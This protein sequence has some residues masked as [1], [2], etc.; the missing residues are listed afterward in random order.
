MKKLFVLICLLALI[1]FTG[2]AL[3]ASGGHVTSDDTSGGGGGGCNAGYAGIILF[4]AVPLFF[5]KKK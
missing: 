3:A 5:L 1:S 2:A 4:V